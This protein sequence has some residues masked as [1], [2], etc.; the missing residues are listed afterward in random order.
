MKKRAIDEALEMTQALVSGAISVTE[1]QFEFP[2][3]ITKQYKKVCRED[4]E[5]ADLIYVLLVEGGTDVGDSMTDTNFLKLMKRQYEDVLQG[6][7]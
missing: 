6:V 5:Y 4:A 3:F 7:W 1:Y 2:Y